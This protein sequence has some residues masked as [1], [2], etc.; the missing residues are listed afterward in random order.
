[1]SESFDDLCLLAKPTAASIATALESR[2][3]SQ[4]IYTAIG[5]VTIAVNPFQWLP[6]CVLFP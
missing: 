1:M 6:L 5:T 2:L 4:D 3:K